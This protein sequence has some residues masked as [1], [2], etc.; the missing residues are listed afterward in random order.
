M[1]QEWHK[2]K[3]TGIS[4]VSFVI[5]AQPPRLL[6]GG[7]KKNKETLIWS[8]RAYCCRRC[9]RY[10]LHNK[11]LGFV[12]CGVFFVCLGEVCL[13]I[14]LLVCFFNALFPPSSHQSLWST[15]AQKSLARLQHS[16]TKSD[17]RK[18]SLKF[19]SE[20]IHAWLSK[21]IKLTTRKGKNHINTV[22]RHP[23]HNGNQSTEVKDRCVNAKLRIISFPNASGRNHCCTFAILVFWTDVLK[24]S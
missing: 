11:L 16:K 4:S 7:F 19:T 15:L 21:E 22:Q 10:H 8:C 1:I 17:F 6:L 24:C 14:L 9:P 13:F 20:A 3:V 23:H 12:V 18:Y 2:P 5:T